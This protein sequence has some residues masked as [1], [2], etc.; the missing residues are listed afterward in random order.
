VMRGVSRTCG[1]EQAR[2]GASKPARPNSVRR[3]S[4]GIDPL[5]PAANDRCRQHDSSIS[6]RSSAK[7]LCY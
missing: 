4:A 5:L 3:Q 1:Y 7:R 2:Y 6:A